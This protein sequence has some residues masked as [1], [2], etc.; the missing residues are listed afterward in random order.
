ML[1]THRLPAYFRLG[2]VAGLMLSLLF[3]CNRKSTAEAECAAG[4]PE[5]IF[6]QDLSGIIEHKFNRSGQEGEEVV[7]F[8]DDLELTIFQSGCQEIR[9]EY[10]F[11]LNQP[12][13]EG[14]WFRKAAELF[15]R[16]ASLE[17][18]YFPYNAWGNA[19]ERASGQYALAEIWEAEPGFFIQTDYIDSDS[20]PVLIVVLAQGGN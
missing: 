19:I 4:L 16:L 18:S 20:Q 12:I 13:E 2:L 11:Y 9:Q 10:H 8:S 1:F 3:S 6:S 17:E 14:D 5:P 7:L 15:Y